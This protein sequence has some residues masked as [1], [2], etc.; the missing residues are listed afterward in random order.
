MEGHEV[1]VKW[2]LRNP[3]AEVLREDEQELHVESLSATWLEK[4]DFGA[5]KL[6]EAELYETYV[7]YQL[8]END[9]MISEGTVLFCPPKHFR[10]EDPELSICVEYDEIVV[11][12]P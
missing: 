9:E 12:S 4:V 7:S 3:K 6:G 1:T 10:F 11:R 8:Y 2:Q 5:T